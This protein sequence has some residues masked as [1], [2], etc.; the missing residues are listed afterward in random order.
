MKKTQTAV[1]LRSRTGDELPEDLGHPASDPISTASFVANV[2][3]GGVLIVVCLGML[4]YAAFGLR[5]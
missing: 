3:V 5:W 1:P 4:A 2:I